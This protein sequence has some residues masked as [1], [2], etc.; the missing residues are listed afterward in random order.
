MDMDIALE[1]KVPAYRGISRY[2][3]VRRDLAL[4]VE[5]RISAESLVKEVREGVGELLREVRI[6]DIYRGDP[7]DSG[8][9][10]VALGLILQ[11]SS[12][13]LTDDDVEGVVQAVISRL[14]RTLKARIRD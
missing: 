3:A 8:L 4:L 7:I 10:S 14:E 5:E 6:F 2:P 13:T 1:S 9:K 11:D 12:R